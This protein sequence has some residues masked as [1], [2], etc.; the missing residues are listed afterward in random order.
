[1]KN[2]YRGISLFLAAGIA[3]SGFR[4]YNMDGYIEARRRLS[5]RGENRGAA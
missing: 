2:P 5:G 3:F 4:G 1:M